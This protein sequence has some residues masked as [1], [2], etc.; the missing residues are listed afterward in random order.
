M[1]EKI[2]SIYSTKRLNRIFEK[3]ELTRT[4]YMVKVHELRS[5]TDEELNVLMETAVERYPEIVA[6]SYL[7]TADHEL[8]AEYGERYAEYALRYKDWFED[9]ETDL[10]IGFG[11]HEIK[12]IL[13]TYSR[14]NIPSYD[15]DCKKI[16]EKLREDY[17]KEQKLYA[18][19]GRQ[20]KENWGKITL[21]MNEH[22]FPEPDL[23]NI[24][25]TED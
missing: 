3:E 5:K 19:M 25:L 9:V 20:H 10:I 1:L 8:R 22:G 14:L 6:F 7:A 13:K 11:E 16:M 23:R 24:D 12:D 15:A 2:H 17:L 18:D 4:Q 21:T